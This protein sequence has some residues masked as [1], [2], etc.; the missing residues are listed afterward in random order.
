MSIENSNPNSPITSASSSFIYNSMV[1]NTAV[2]LLTPASNPNGAIVHYATVEL[3]AG[4][5]LSLIAKSSAPT[6]VSD[7]KVLETGVKKTLVA[8]IATE[9][10]LNKS[11]T[12]PA[13][14]GVYLIS[15]TVGTAFGNIQITIL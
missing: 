3:T 14:T 2:T 8:A 12:V 11:I 15:D 10:K 7:G 13:G 1:V 4:A 5:I 9:L 6:T